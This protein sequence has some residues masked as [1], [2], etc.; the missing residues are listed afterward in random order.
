LSPAKAKRSKAKVSK[1]KA[2]KGKPSK[3]KP[4][5]AKPLKAK[6]SKAKTAKAQ[7]AKAKSAKAKSAKAKPSKGKATKPKSPAPAAAR[8]FRFTAA[9]VVRI[10]FKGEKKPENFRVDD[11][12][13]AS[14]NTMQG[15]TKLYFQYRLVSNDKTNPDG[16][17]RSFWFFDPKPV[18]AADPVDPS[19]WQ[20][21]KDDTTVGQAVVEPC[22]GAFSTRSVTSY[23]GSGMRLVVKLDDKPTYRMRLELN[24][25]TE[26]CESLPLVIRKDDVL[27][28]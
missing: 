13:E 22:S 12:V 2:A 1:A 8:P 28:S 10:H 24:G 25:K 18:G 27:G 23:D 6:P 16:S 7:T 11:M 21:V 4:S 5:K 19:L 14:M 26:F 15:Q 17:E 9:H 20:S 3:A